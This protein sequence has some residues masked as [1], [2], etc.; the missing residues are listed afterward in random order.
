[1]LPAG[2]A[3][4]LDSDDKTEFRCSGANLAALSA[5]ALAS[6]DKACMAGWVSNNPLA[7]L[8]LEKKIAK[9]PG[10]IFSDIPS[11]DSDAFSRLITDQNMPS[12]TSEHW[13]TLLANPANCGHI[14]KLDKFD[15]SRLP[16]IGFACIA[17]MTQDVREAIFSSD[18]GIKKLDEQ[19]L[20]HFNKDLVTAEELQSIGKKRPAL[21]KHIGKF[22][23]V[24]EFHPCNH[25]RLDDYKGKGN[26][27]IRSVLDNS[28]PS[29]ILIH[30]RS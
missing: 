27:A 2:L 29:C 26:K 11:G 23:A 7:A 19:V 12:F 28:N 4:Q 20:A 17:N 18:A 1:M 10:G 9:L 24:G 25:F 3:A 13:K 22:V 6:V 21:L 14:K 30:R 15:W 16:P 8:V 5:P